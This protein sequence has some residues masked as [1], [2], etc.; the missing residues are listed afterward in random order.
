MGRLDIILCTAPPASGGGANSLLEE[1]ASLA[2]ESLTRRVDQVLSHATPRRVVSAI[3]ARVRSAP[4]FSHQMN[5]LVGTE[6]SREILMGLLYELTYQ[7]HGEDAVPLQCMLFASDQASVRCEI[8]GQE[9]MGSVMEVMRGMQRIVLV[10]LKFRSR[11]MALVVVKQLSTTLIASMLG[12]AWCNVWLMQGG[13]VSVERSAAVLREALTVRDAVEGC[14]HISEDALAGIV[15][16]GAVLQARAL[17]DGEAQGLAA[18]WRQLTRGGEAAS[19]DRRLV[20]DNAALRAAHAELQV[21]LGEREECFAKE[22][23]A[24]Q[25]EIERLRQSLQQAEANGEKL[26]EAEARVALLES[27]LA[28]KD[29]VP[30]SQR[31]QIDRNRLEASKSMQPVEIDR[32]NRLEQLRD[33]IGLQKYGDVKNGLRQ[34]LSETQAALRSAQQR[35]EALRK[36]SLQNVM[37]FHEREKEWQVVLKRG[38][39][40]R[41]ILAEECRQLRSVVTSQ[42]S[43]LDVVKEAVESTRLLQEL[44][45]DELLKKIRAISL[46]SASASHRRVSPRRARHSDSWRGL[47][48]LSPPPLVKNCYS[49]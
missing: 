40:E 6:D 11:T 8:V 48:K 30:Q 36:E 29:E 13:L 25:R 42:G 10:A 46:A 35:W 15:D 38:E 41:D 3:A 24:M 9:E 47:R 26:K 31:D 37:E 19:E 49:P 7:Q 32:H 27:R 18:R 33:G 16:L 44:E 2:L 5:I 17:S 45:L 43:S 28:E 1:Q 20:E 12:S 39:K 34:E 14:C 23:G 4:A 21:Y 22:N